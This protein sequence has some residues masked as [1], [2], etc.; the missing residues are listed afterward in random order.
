VVG[1]SAI[2]GS[3]IPLAPFAFLPITTSMWVSVVI[4]ALILFLVG[5]YKARMTVGHPGRSGLEMALIGTLSALVG[6]VVGMLLKVP[7]TP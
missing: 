7:T 5:V 2:V 6:F 3:L 1:F 4:T